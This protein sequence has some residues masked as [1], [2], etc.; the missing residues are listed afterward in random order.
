MAT[1]PA[2]G[3][4]TGTGRRDRATRRRLPASTAPREPLRASARAAHPVPKRSWTPTGRRSPWRWTWIPRGPME[5]AGDALGF[6]KR[7]V[8]GTS[9]G[10]RMSSSPAVGNPAPVEGRSQEASAAHDDCAQLPAT[11]PRT[12]NCCARCNVPAR[13]RPSERMVRR[14]ARP[15]RRAG[16]SAHRDHHSADGWGP[17]RSTGEPALPR[18]TIAEPD[19][20]EPGALDAGADRAPDLVCL[21]RSAD[22]D[23]SAAPLARSALRDRQDHIQRDQRH[24]SECEDR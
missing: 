19:R 21:A 3:V 15:H 10:S 22:R 2:R 18:P 14:A 24:R 7:Q 8:H 4:R 20:R 13:M 5:S 23:A 6:I 11:A 17:T 1:G 9:S 16:S 12:V